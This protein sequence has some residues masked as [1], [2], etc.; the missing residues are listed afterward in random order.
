MAGSNL[1]GMHICMDKKPEAYDQT[2]EDQ[3]AQS[4]SIVHVSN[5][6][7]L[8]NPPFKKNA[9]VKCVVCSR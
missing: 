1:P 8:E 7:G 6:G 3:Q 9:A 4:L 2:R 5:D